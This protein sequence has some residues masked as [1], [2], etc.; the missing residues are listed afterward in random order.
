MTRRAIVWMFL[1]GRYAH[2]NESQRE[3]Y[4]SLSAT[5]FFSLLQVEFAG[6]MA[7]CLR[8]FRVLSEL[9]GKALAELR[10]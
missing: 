1:Y 8:C 7:F 9:N 5:P 2:A 10:A 4:A 6:A 3:L